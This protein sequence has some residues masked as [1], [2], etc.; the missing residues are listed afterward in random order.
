MNRHETILRREDSLL[1]VIDFQQRLV[2]VMPRKESV[3]DEITR[4]I[5]GMKQ[6]NIPILATEQY[7][8]GLGP[9]VPSVAEELEPA[10]IF[11]KMTFS[12]CGLEDFGARLK[13]LLRRQVVVT[14]IET[15]VCVLQTVLD[16]LANGYQV[17]VPVGATCSRADVNR[18]NAL[19]RMEKAGAVLTNLESVLFELLVEAGT[20]DFKAVRKLIV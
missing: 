19:A 3:T 6:L 17:H 7:P 18:D 15:H 8:Q 5:Q 10:P 1:V 20:D 12:C 4:L 14:G 16:L 2:D 11:S 9:T 13:N